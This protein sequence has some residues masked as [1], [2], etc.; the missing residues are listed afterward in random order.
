MLSKLIT[1]AALQDDT[2]VRDALES[3][4]LKEKHNTRITFE[5]PEEDMIGE[6]L[7]GTGRWGKGYREGEGGGRAAT[8]QG[9]NSRQE[10]A[11]IVTGTYRMGAEGKGFN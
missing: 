2:K 4:T 8:R 6:A 3:S 10:M 1:G 9:L 7:E 5:D 11:Y